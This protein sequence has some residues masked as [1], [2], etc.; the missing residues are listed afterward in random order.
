[1]IEELHFEPLPP[2]TALPDVV[3]AVAG[4]QAKCVRPNVKP[5]D[6]KATDH[7]KN[8]FAHKPYNLTMNLLGW[9][10]VRMGDPFDST[11]TGASNYIFMEPASNSTRYSMVNNFVVPYGLHF[12]Q[13]AFGEGSMHSTLDCE[14]FGS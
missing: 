13:K 8:I 10:E 14:R 6:P 11:S 2:K 9:N 12:F 3:N 5:E 4:F 7:Y 1:L